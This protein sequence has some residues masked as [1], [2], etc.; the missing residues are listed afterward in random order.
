[1]ATAMVNG[2]PRPVSPGTLLSQLLA[3]DA[4]LETPCGGRG[5]C[6]KCRVIARGELSEPSEEEKRCLSEE[7]LARGLRLACCTRALGDCEISTTAAAKAHV[8]ADGDGLEPVHPLFSRYGAAVDSVAVGTLPVGLPHYLETFMQA[9]T[10]VSIKQ[11]YG[12]AA[13][14]CFALLLLFLLYDSPL[15]RDTKLMPAWQQV[16]RQ[17]AASLPGR[18]RGRVMRI[19]RRHP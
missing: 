5:R 10:A 19:F 15:R 7:E 1:M 9:V 4:Q 11:L 17:V 6:G 3:P 16:R 8:L 18:K 2:I 13:Y 12:W 14:A